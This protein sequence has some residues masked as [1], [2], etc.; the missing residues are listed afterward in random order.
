VMYLG[1]IRDKLTYLLLWSVGLIA[2][3]AF[4]WSWRRRGGAVTFVE[5][6]M[7]H[8]WAAGV[9]ASV[10]LFIVEYMLDLDVLKLSPL[11]A[12]IAGMVFLFEAGTLSGWFYIAA[13][14]SFATT[15]PMILWPQI[16]PML[17]GIVSAFGFFVPG[18]K[19]Y[20]QKRRMEKRSPLAG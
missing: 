10:G 6:Q 20:R 7:A 4:F 19:Y 12:V 14:V 3:G 2:W 8:A 5:R 18:L 15:I 1:G 17:F 13:T 9:I 11:L 16:A